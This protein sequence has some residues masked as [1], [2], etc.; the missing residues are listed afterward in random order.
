MK[1]NAVDVVINAGTRKWLLLS[2]VMDEMASENEFSFN[3]QKAY[4]S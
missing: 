1:R 4:N 2:A 3:K